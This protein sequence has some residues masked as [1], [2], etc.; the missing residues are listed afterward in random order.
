MTIE[1]NIIG[2]NDYFYEALKDRLIRAGILIVEKPKLSTI[3]IG[4]DTDKDVD[5]LIVPGLTSNTNS[6]LVI[7]IYDLLI[8]EGKNKWGSDILFEWLENIKKNNNKPLNVDA[9]H[10][11][12]HI[13]DAIEAILVLL[14]SEESSII[15]GKLNLSG[16]RAWSNDSVFEELEMLLLRYTNSIN[17][18]HTLESLSN[19]PDPV[20]KNKKYIRERPDLSLLDKELLRAGGDGWHPL[21]P[22]RTGLMELLAQNL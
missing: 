8:P 5:I 3:K 11:W 13:R 15:K 21:T 4:L 22:L 17:Y 14:L 10:Y 7:S 12:V 19:I 20:K 1:V 9:I 18:S 6:R 16:R 2:E